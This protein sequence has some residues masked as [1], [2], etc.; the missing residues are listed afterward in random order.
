VDQGLAVRHGSNNSKQYCRVER[1][2]RHSL[3][4]Q[5]QSRSFSW[6]VAAASVG[7]GSGHRK[8]GVSK[9]NRPVTWLPPD[10]HLTAALPG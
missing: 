8:R 7:T 5:N 4:L 2:Q 1:W 3:Q 9:L 10:C 6:S